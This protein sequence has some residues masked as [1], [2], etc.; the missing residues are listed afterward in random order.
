MVAAGPL[1]ALALGSGAVQHVAA[2]PVG[3]SLLQPRP[4]R[5]EGRAVLR[6][7]THNHYFSY[8]IHFARVHHPSLMPFQH[9]CQRWQLCFG[10]TRLSVP[11]GMG[12]EGDK[13]GSDGRWAAVWTI[14]FCGYPGGDGMGTASQG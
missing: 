14:C 8:L 11:A 10:D 5:Q 7:S 2:V 3:E 13:L 9:Q 4:P 12:P 1:V 6:K